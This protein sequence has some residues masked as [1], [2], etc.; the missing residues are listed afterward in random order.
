MMTAWMRWVAAAFG[1]LLVLVIVLVY[2]YVIL[3]LWGFPFHAQRRG[4][5][6]LVPAWALE[7]WLWEDDIKTADFVTEMLDGYLE[8]D[9][10]VGA[11][12]IDAPWAMRNND[13]VV[14]EDR[15]PN[16]QT[17]FRELKD[18][19]GVR[20]AFW[21]T[22]NVNSISKEMPVNDSQD[23]YEEAKR[24]GY[25]IDRGGQIQWWRG[26]GGRIDYTHPEAMVWW[27][28]MQ[29]QIF[30]LGLDAWKLDDTS[31]YPNM[32]LLG[33]LPGCYHRTH[34]GWMTTR[35]YM[36]H[37]YREE[38]RHGLTQNPEFV[39]MG[40][41]IDSILPWAH[42][43][44]FSPLDAA[45]LSWV[46]DN[47]HL[48]SYRERGLER[49]IVCILRSA[50]LGYNLP[51]SDIGGYHGGMPIQPELYIRWAQFSTFS[52][53]FLNGGHGE[54]RMWKRTDQELEILR[55]YSWLRSELVP[56]IYCYVVQ[57][58]RGGRVL[59]RPVKGKYHYLFGDA[60]LI[61]PIYEDSLSRTVTL[62]Q[63]RWRYWFDD[64]EVMDG[65]TTF[66]RDF[67]MNEYPVYVRDG[68]ILPM[69]ISRAYTGIGEEDWAPYLTLNVYPHETSERT[70][71]HT[72]G[73]GELRVRV[74]VEE[75]KSL[76]IALEGTSKPHLLRILLDGPA[77]RV[78]LEGRDVSEEAWTWRPETRRLIIKTDSPATGTYVVTLHGS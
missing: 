48:W 40:R 29:Q 14:D 21:M 70:V 69:K 49:A 58:S 35:G 57:A 43:E 28:G 16:P 71:Y 20:L 37:Y 66:T 23:F 26:K 8:H 4:N 56:Y 76:R 60:F 55:E 47:R 77:S 54:R 38:Y 42:P 73:S 24:K 12:L 32:N 11:Y 22:P 62:P 2:F 45:T 27:R 65:G 18:R 74:D 6:P 31:T 7:P 36:D 3:P 15:Y 64:Q 30:D 67:P 59:L 39:T 53:F 34:R 5:V 63:G 50:R 10:P 61:A 68:S 9:F 46:G 13:F 51:G 44:G 75:G 33:K 41:S 52:G 72:D 19:T 78:T 17:F 25:L 1:I